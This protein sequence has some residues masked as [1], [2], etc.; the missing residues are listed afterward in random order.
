MGK[1]SKVATKNSGS[2][3]G[4]SGKKKRKTR[5]HISIDE[6]VGEVLDKLYINRSRFI[7]DLLRM[8]LFE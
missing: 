5:L 6:D 2:H 7:N 8:V 1:V 3:S 4:V